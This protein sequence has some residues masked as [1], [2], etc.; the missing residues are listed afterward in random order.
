MSAETL[1]EHHRKTFRLSLD[2]TLIAAGSNLRAEDA[3]ELVEA[4]SWCSPVRDLREDLA[5]GLINIPAEVLAGVPGIEET[6]ALLASEPVR[7]WL[8]AEHGR[9]VRRLRRDPHPPT[10]SPTRTHTHPGE[11]AFV[12]SSLR[13]P[14]LPGGRECVW[15]RGLGGEGS[16]DAGTAILAAF[17]RA[18]AAYEKKYRRLYP[19]LCDA[20]CEAAR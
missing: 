11:G 18:L 20:R 19:D 12:K 14:P 15:E 8:R 3:P 17:H 10:P 1:A 6:N 4:L 7:A 9:A 5:K 2:L 16:N 13:V